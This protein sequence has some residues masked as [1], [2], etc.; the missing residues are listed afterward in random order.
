MLEVDLVESPALGDVE[1]LLEV[2]PL[3]VIDDVEELVG[4]PGL[5]SVLDRGQVGRGVVE[6]AVA[7]P[8]DERGLLALGEDDDGPLALLGDAARFQVLDDLR[9]HRVV[10]ALAELDVEADAEPVVDQ[11]VRASRQW[12]MN[13]CQRARFSGSP[14]WSLAVSARAASSTPLS[15]ALIRS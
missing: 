15:P 3:A 12:G 6:G 11:A 8:N 7:L 9:Q 10:E 5:L 14:A 4:V 2:V 1:E 13:C